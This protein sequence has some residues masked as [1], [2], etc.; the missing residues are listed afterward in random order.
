[1]IFRM[2]KKEYIEYFHQYLMLGI[3]IFFVFLQNK[4]FTRIKNIIM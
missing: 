3:W 4:S 1:M 2:H